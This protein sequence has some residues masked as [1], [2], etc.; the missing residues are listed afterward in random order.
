MCM[1]I[2]SSPGLVQ[3]RIE[4]LLIAPPDGLVA[5]STVAD[6]CKSIKQLGTTA[7][8]PDTEQ[9]VT[10]LTSESLQL[11]LPHL[12]AKLLNSGD[13]S[14]KWLDVQYVCSV[15]SVLGAAAELYGWLPEGPSEAPNVAALIE[16]SGETRFYGQQLLLAVAC[17]PFTYAAY[18]RQP[19]QLPCL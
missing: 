3:Q 1:R 12:L 18:C 19:T 6:V 7:S 17:W 11:K 4:Q 8:S 9:Q 15:S 14:S 13:S 2:G 5:S 10:I 16:E